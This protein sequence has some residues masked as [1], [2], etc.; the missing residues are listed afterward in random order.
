MKQV[1]S[2]YKCQVCGEEKDPDEVILGALVRKSLVNEVKKKHAHWSPNNYICTEDLNKF[3]NVYV[4]DLLKVER[5]ELTK[6]EKDL[7]QSLKQHELLSKNINTEFDRKLSFGEKLSD[8][9]AEFGG[10]WKFL[11][12]FG[13][14]LTIWII[15]NSIVLLTRVFDPYPFILLNLILS[16]LAAV[17]API[18]MMSQNRQESK[19]RLRSEY[20]YKINMKAELEIRYL[21]EKVDQL[22]NHQWNRLIEIQQIQM[23]LIQE[24]KKHK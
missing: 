10:S 5:G 23:D 21:N 12:I 6:I 2:K 14:I 4:E 11:I 20:D 17:Q 7:I 22:I 19:D 9:I 15:I 13:L 18:I 1:Q 16:S 3:R 24:L 8:K